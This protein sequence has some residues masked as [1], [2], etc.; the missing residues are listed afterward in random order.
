MNG[1]RSYRDEQ[2]LST[3]VRRR[4]RNR[5]ITLVLLVALNVYLAVRVATEIAWFWR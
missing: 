2:R 5:S 4:E 3:I 1:T